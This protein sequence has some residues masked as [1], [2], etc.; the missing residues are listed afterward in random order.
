MR[1]GIVISS[2]CLSAI[3]SWLKILLS[4]VLTSVLDN[5]SATV[6]FPLMCFTGC[7]LVCANINRV[8]HRFVIREDYE[9]DALQE[10][11]EMTDVQVDSQEFL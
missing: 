9:T 7:V 5:A 6:F 8:G 11:L 1:S 4:R 3:S 10:V 2:F